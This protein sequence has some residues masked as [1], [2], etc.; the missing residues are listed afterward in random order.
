MPETKQV[1]FQCHTPDQEHRG[2]H[3]KNSL[4][5]LPAASSWRRQA[6]GSMGEATENPVGLWGGAWV[7]ERRKSLG[8]G[9]P[10]HRASESP[11]TGSSNRVEGP[12]G[13]IQGQRHAQDTRGPVDQLLC[14]QYLL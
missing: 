3:S 6:L 13:D 4:E 5:E 9:T 7:Q 1:G 11:F 8:P 10:S 14:I 2:L 12:T